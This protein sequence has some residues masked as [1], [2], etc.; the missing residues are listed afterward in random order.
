MQGFVVNYEETKAASPNQIMQTYST[1]QLPVL[2]ALARNFAISDAW[3]CSVP[4]QTWPNRSF[5]H[6]GTSN[7]NV[8]NGVITNPFHWDVMTIFN[9]LQSMGASWKV[10]NDSFTSSLTRIMF[11][12][13]WSPLLNR[14]FQGFSDFQSDCAAGTLPQ[15]SFV[16]PNFVSAEANDEHPPHDVAAGER[17]L[18]A[19]WQAISQSPAWESTLLLITFD[20]HGGCYDHVLPPTNAVVP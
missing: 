1:T 5:V 15:Y 11:P 6:A 20:E 8:D 17:F 19:I 12:K 10:Y 7:G 13:L 2:T 18:F 14:H 16:E 9:V 3:F 4:S